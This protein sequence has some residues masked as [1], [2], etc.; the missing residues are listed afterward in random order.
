MVSQAIP[1][2]ARKPKVIYV[3]YRWD[4]FSIAINIEQD[5]IML[6]SCDLHPYYEDSRVSWVIRSHY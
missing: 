6:P 3:I 4:S 5:F 1:T 2:L